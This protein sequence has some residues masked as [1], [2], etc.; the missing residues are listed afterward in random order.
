MSAFRRSPRRPPRPPSVRPRTGPPGPSGAPSRC[1]RPRSTPPVSQIPV[2]PR[3]P[4]S[5]TSPVCPQQQKCV[6]ELGRRL[7]EPVRPVDGLRVGTRGRRAAGHPPDGEATGKRRHDGRRSG[8]AVR[9]ADPPAG[10]L[11]L[12]V[13]ADGNGS[14]AELADDD[15]ARRIRTRRLVAGD[16][17]PLAALRIA[18]SACPSPRRSVDRS[19]CSRR[20]RRSRRS[21]GALPPAR[22]PTAPQRTICRIAPAARA[23]APGPVATACPASSTRCRPRRCSPRRSA[24]PAGRCHGPSRSAPGGPPYRCVPGSSGGS[25]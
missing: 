4:P 7:D 6:D 2:R 15:P 21:S 5:P 23:L 24:A 17:L 22:R 12:R 3:R 8:H 20:S 14:S 25:G 18:L 1:S 10:V 13:P 9:P 19:C 11:R 16:R